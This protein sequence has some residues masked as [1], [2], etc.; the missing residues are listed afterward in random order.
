[1]STAIGREQYIG[2]NPH[3]A[4]SDRRH[5][6]GLE[7]RNHYR[8]GIRSA[9]VLGAVSAALIL[10]GAWLAFG[11][12]HSANRPADGPSSTAA[13]SHTVIAHSAYQQGQWVAS[14]Q[15]TLGL[16]Y[17][18]IG[19]DDG[20]LGPQTRQ[21]IIGFQKANGLTSDGVAGPATM[22]LMNHQLITG[23]N[24]MGPSG[25]PVKTATGTNS[26]GTSTTGSSTTTPTGGGSSTGGAS[27]T[28]T[29]AAASAP[30]A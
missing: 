23:D 7:H 26:K 27:V 2:E 3:Y 5:E 9:F 22:A 14:L 6:S 11:A 30:G 19:P 24:H 8:R 13:A 10:G 28:T 17:Y 1:M 12:G 18:Y 20:V 29:P 21:A 15:H 4:D 25:P 16:L